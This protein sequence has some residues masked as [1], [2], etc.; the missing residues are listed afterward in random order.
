MDQFPP[1]EAAKKR[2]HGDSDSHDGA[3]KLPGLISA[4]VESC[5][6]SEGAED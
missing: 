3:S 6:S 1:S 4:I 5:N 2:K